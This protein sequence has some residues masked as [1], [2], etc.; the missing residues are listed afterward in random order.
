MTNWRD[1]H[2]VIPAV[3]IIFRDGDKILLLKRANT[4]YHDGDYSL[5]AGH[6]DG[7]ESAL[8]AAIREA[9]EEVG[10]TLAPEAMQLIYTQ[11]RMAEE[12]DHERINLFFEATKWEGTPTNMEPDKCSELSWANIHTLPDNLVPELAHAL[13]HIAAHKLYGH[14][15]FSATDDAV[16]GM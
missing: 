1:R 5:P 10:I 11:H 8:R 12:G 13:P 6:L 16:Q 2:S 15:A 14:F 7:G 4:G 3:Y 9:K